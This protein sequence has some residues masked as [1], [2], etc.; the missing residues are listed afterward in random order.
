MAR[1]YQFVFY[2][3]WIAPHLL[4]IPVATALF[5]RR[6]HKKFPIFFAYT[7]YEILE[8]LLLFISYKLTH[9]LGVTYRYVFITTLVGSTALA[10]AVLQEILADAFRDY[11]SL[12]LVSRVCVRCVIGALILAA[13]MSTLW[14]SGPSDNTLA[15]VELMERGVTIIQSGL[16]LFLFLFSRFF[17]V[18]WRSYTFG[19]ALGFAIFGSAQIVTWTLGLTAVSEHSKQ[20]VDLI[21]TGS[22]HVSVLVW[23]GYLVAMEKPV[24]ALPHSVPE[25]KQWSGELERSR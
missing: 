3:L 14:Y 1:A 6:L 25:L 5:V 11:P 10:L 20:L 7:L 12:E 15:R 13:L 2:Y 19:I 9:G 17:G 22:Y 23:L 18:S 24:S 4:L 21:P 8:F 16:L